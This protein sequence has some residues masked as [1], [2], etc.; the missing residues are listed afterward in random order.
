MTWVCSFRHPFLLSFINHI[1][2]IDHII[3]SSR[4]KFFRHFIWLPFHL[5]DR[6]F[7]FV[8]LSSISLILSSTL[9]LIRSSIHPIHSPR[10]LI[11]RE[12]NP[13]E[14]EIA[15]LIQESLARDRLRAQHFA[16]QQAALQAQQEAMDVENEVR[17][18]AR[19]RW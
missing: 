14:S 2:H 5:F 13:E 6:R 4:L 12:K 15:R 8:L 10:F 1:D 7:D 18:S 17:V 19:G 3:A 11:G 16:Q 9:S